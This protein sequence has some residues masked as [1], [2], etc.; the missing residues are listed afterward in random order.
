[1]LP[2]ELKL[3]LVQPGPLAEESQGSGRQVTGMRPNYVYIF[4]YVLSITSTS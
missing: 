3:G 2:V 1:M 4:G